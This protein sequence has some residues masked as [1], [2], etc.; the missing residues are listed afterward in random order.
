MDE[1]DRGLEELKKM[2]AGEKVSPETEKKDYLGKRDATETEPPGV[3]LERVERASPGKDLAIHA[4]VSDPSGVKLVRLRYRHLT[5]F[6]DYLSMDMIPDPATGV[7][8]A[9]IPGGF[10]VPEQDLI[11]FIEAMDEHGNGCMIPDLELEM[12]YV[13]VRTSD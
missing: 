7:Y 9:R 1:L 10:I 2:R 3:T 11:Y 4:R 5:Q 12:P 8:G 13:I 6:E